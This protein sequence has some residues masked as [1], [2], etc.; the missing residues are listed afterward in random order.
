MTTMTLT[1]TPQGINAVKVNTRLVYNGIIAELTKTAQGRWEGKLKSG[2]TFEIFG[3]SAAGGK[4]T[5]WF[6]RDSR[7]GDN[8]LYAKSAKAIIELMHHI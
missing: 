7:V 6:L 4:A 8:T 2:H 5:D 1:Q 3:G